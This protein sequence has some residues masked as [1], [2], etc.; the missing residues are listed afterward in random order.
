MKFKDRFQAGRF[1]TAQL[2]SYRDRRDVIVLALPRGGVAVGYEVSLALNAPLDVLVVRKI[3]HPRFREL[4]I[5]AITSS[6]GNLPPGTARRCGLEERELHE[7]M[8]QERLELARREKCFR[9]NKPFPD[10]T[11]RTVILVDDGMAT[12]STMM[13]AL[14]AVRLQEPGRIVVAVPVGAVDSCC[15]LSGLVDDMVCTYVPRAFKAVGQWYSN[16]AQSTDE[17][18]ERLLHRAGERAME[19]S[20]SWELE[21]ERVSV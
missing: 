5:G 2:A 18:V 15:H 14:K 10:L 12:G 16:F 21:E 1:L 19:P 11:G 8:G 13:A 7:V 6:S 9:D 4:G 20:P 3:G 17:E